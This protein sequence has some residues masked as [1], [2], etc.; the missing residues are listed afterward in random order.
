M[1]N[2]EIYEIMKYM[3]F[4]TFYILGQIKES[5]HSI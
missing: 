5:Y 3:K 4:L 1:S 2:I